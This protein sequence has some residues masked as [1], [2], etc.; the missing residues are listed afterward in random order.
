M[1]RRRRKLKPWAEN[2]VLALAMTAMWLVVGAMALN[3]WTEH[4][5]EQHVTGT[6]YMEA[7]GG[8]IG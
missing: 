1:K 3:V 7:I 4:P 5:A 8:G 6:A 2:A